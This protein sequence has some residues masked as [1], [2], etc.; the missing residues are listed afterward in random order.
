MPLKVS[1]FG[2]NSPSSVWPAEN[3]IELPLALL[4]QLKSLKLANDPLIVPDANGVAY[5]N[6]NYW[7]PLMIN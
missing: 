7:V 3:E 5:L 2:D 4:T 1:T 6:E